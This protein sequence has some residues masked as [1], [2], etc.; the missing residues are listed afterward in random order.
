MKIK[1]AY[2]VSAINSGI[3]AHSFSVDVPYSSLNY[4]VLNL[5]LKYNLISN[6]S[7]SN[8]KFSV[9]LRYL[10]GR[11]VIKRLNLIS[12]LKRYVYLNKSNLRN[13]TRSGNISGFYIL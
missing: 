9:I 12:T 8:N 4:E 5:F 11:G 3:L 10:N 2:L 7:F 13:K 6:F 1:L